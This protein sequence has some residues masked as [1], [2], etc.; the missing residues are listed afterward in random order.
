M[1]MGRG[2]GGMRESEWKKC[3]MFESLSL[4]LRLTFTTATVNH[5][6]V[7]PPNANTRR[8]K[9]ALHPSPTLHERQPDRQH[10]THS[11]PTTAYSS[12]NGHT[13]A[14]SS[15]VVC[16]CPRGLLCL[17]RHRRAVRA[18]SSRTRAARVR[19]LSGNGLHLRR[20]LLSGLLL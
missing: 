11:R 17:L 19:N 10:L 1:G 9:C 20:R 6:H 14:I 7:Y 2:G 4:P 3:S 12:R 18:S 13:T 16:W 5:P 15:L 8:L